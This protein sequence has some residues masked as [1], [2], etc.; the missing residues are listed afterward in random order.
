MAAAAQPPRAPAPG[1]C[2]L[3]DLTARFE[4]AQTGRWRHLRA[5]V[6]AIA[7]AQAGAAAGAQEARGKDGAR[8]LRFAALPVWF[9]REWGE[10]IWANLSTAAPQLFFVFRADEGADGAITPLLTLAGDEAAGYGETDAMV[11]SLPMPNWLLQT[12]RAFVAAHY[13]P[14]PKKV[15]KR[16]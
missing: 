4:T 14:Q 3:A 2:V 9:L 5:E 6:L 10:S 15:R 7:P 13:R 16:Q 8:L 11:V 1:S 12:A